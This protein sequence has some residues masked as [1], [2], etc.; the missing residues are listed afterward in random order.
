MHAR[1]AALVAL[2]AL[3]VAAL[4][5]L[6]TAHAIP[7][8]EGVQLILG[9]DDEDG[10]IEP[11]QEVTVYAAA[12][13]PG[14]WGSIERM[15]ATDLKLFSSVGWE[16]SYSPWL[17]A[18][19]SGSYKDPG[20][21]VPDTNPYVMGGRRIWAYLPNDQSELHLGARAMMLMKAM[22]KRTAI[23]VSNQSAGRRS[24]WVFDTWNKRQALVIPPSLANAGDTFGISEASV[25]SQL[26]RAYHG[27]AVAVWHETEDLA[28]IF[29][30]EPGAAG[31]GGQANIGR[32]H[33]ISL[34]WSTNPPIAAHRGSLQP[35]VAEAANFVWST[36]Y[37]SHHTASYGS[38]VTIS[39]DGSTLA[40]SAPRIN[41]IGAVYVYTRPD[42]PGQ[43]WADISY[44]NG[45]KVTQMVTPHWGTSE[46]AS[47]APYSSA[48]PTCDAHCSA[49][50]ANWYARLGWRT[51]GLSADGRV[52]TAAAPGKEFPDAHGGGNFGSG[53]RNE[54]GEAYVWLAPQNGWQSATDVVSGKQV[55]PGKA[56]LPADFSW[57][58]HITAGPNRRITEPTRVLLSRTWPTAGNLYGYFGQ[59]I[60]IT[61]DGTT[62]AAGMGGRSN[63]NDGTGHVRFHTFQVAA[64][65]DWDAAR[66]DNP[67][68]EDPWVNGIEVFSLE[69]YGAP[70]WCGFAFNNAGTRLYVGMCGAGGG[71]APGQ[72]RVID[73]P[74]DGAWDSGS[75]NSL[76]DQQGNRYIVDEPIGQTRGNSYGF[77]L[78]SLSDERLA[79]SALGIKVQDHSSVNGNSHISNYPGQ[80]YFSDAGCYERRDDSGNPYLTC[81]LIRSDDESRHTFVVPPGT[82][83]GPLTLSGR[84]TL[85]MFRDRIRGVDSENAITITSKP[86]TLRIGTVQQIAEAR[87]A[88]APRGDGGSHPSSLATG[89]QTVLRLQ[90]LD[91]NGG[92][93]P[94]DSLASIIATTTRGSLSFN[95]HNSAAA[96]II[97]GCAGGGGGSCQID[98]SQ[99]S[100]FAYD[101]SQV[102]RYIGASAWDSSTPNTLDDNIR[103]TLTHSG[104]A[105]PADVSVRAI[106]KT[107]QSFSTEV[108]RVNLLGPPTALSI[109]APA[110]GLLN[111]DTPDA[112]LDADNRDIL[113][114]AVTAVDEHGAKAPLP[115]G[116]SLRAALTDP[117]GKR[118]ASGVALEWPLGGADNPTLNAA[119]DRQVRINV[120]RAAAQPLANGQYTLSLRVGTLSAEQ[121]LR[122]SG[123][124]AAVALNPNSLD[125]PLDADFTVTATLTDAEGDPVPDGTAVEWTEIAAA[126]G[127]AGIVQRSAERATTGGQ[128]S[129]TYLAV[130]PGR[131]TLTAASSGITG[132]ALVAVPAP[133]QPSIAELLTAASPNAFATWLG[134]QTIQAADLLPALDGVAAI[135]TW[136]N[137]RWLRYGVAKGQ[138]LPGSTDFPIPPAAILWLSN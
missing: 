14:Q 1:A 71:P 98:I 119:G 133:P 121:T 78:Y 35:S 38:A 79:V 4:L 96:G 102:L 61:R 117:D 48:A 83:D 105:G 127:A 94:L 75:I 8:P 15:I 115:A 106:A 134:A 95:I 37:T 64:P 49:A 84:V 125:A 27:I 21:F 103:L 26:N 45:V 126:R 131:I 3:L 46:A 135:A 51:I 112:G 89:E 67:A 56:A 17:D 16:N 52:L 5:A 63:R 132:V 23:A 57:N 123:G 85:S 116:G 128:A 87:L 120:N 100:G 50:R 130:S 59:F 34:D 29:A 137:G 93:A 107:G 55:I 109:A 20:V 11:G 18:T 104:A 24:L 72:L 70:N 9:T 69:G 22:D 28:W 12:R 77:P 44:D 13:I 53:V 60:A 47:T 7:P 73:R 19:V 62:V 136:R 91:Q 118:V 81:P 82:P 114:L 32:L 110:G 111:V 86:L 113:T 90:L 25:H 54:R 36:D 2:L 80:T 58:S 68:S 65:E 108:V 6:A 66:P 30:G 10:I 39:A 124:V 33:V 31:P 88:L 40:V 129:A 122:V 92:D 41:Q 97:D 76:G 43:S 42:G 99:L 138:L 74:A 101:R